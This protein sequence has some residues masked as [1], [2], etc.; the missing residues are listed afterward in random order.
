MDLV[1]YI[2][3]GRHHPSPIKQKGGKWTMLGRN[4]RPIGVATRACLR[5]T[6][7]GELSSDVSFIPP[8]PRLIFLANGS[9]YPP[10]APKWHREHLPAEGERLEV[11]EHMA[12]GPAWEDHMT[13]PN[14][15]SPLSA[16]GWLCELR[17][18][19]FLPSTSSVSCSL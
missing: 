12:S 8:P 18:I 19:T 6:F 10:P 2:Q 9:P 16:T 7:T 14:S 3:K 13:S 4:L 17:W 11:Q 15:P 1:T 5:V